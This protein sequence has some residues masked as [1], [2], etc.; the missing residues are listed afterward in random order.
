MSFTFLHRLVFQEAGL[1][2]RHFLSL[3]HRKWAN[4]L[5]VPLTT[6]LDWGDLEGDRVAVH[7]VRARHRA[8]RSWQHSV[9]LYRRRLII[10]GHVYR[11]EL[12]PL[13]PVL[14]TEDQFG[15]SERAFD[16]AVLVFEL[17]V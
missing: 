13:L 14:A 4:L 3:L 1:R 6:S 9:R 11:L 7:Q 10:L 12:A 15:L 17:N 8:V 16:T 5:L 2:S